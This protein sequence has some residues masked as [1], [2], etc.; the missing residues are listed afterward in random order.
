MKTKILVTFILSA[1]LLTTLVAAEVLETN[2]VFDGVF[3]TGEYV[4]GDNEL[5][6]VEIRG[7]ICLDEENMD[8]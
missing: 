6:N 7:Y 4:L 1:I 3:E 5:D 8:I 2:N